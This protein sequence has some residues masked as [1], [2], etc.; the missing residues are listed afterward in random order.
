MGLFEELKRRNVFRVAIAYGVVAWLALQIA[1][2]MID[3]I[4][5]PDWLFGTLLL[6]LAI[7]FPVALVFAWAFEMTP[8]G[9][10]RESEVDRSRSITT[11]TG[12]RLD[13]VIIGVLV[14]ALGY[15]VLERFR[16]ME[17]PGDDPAGTATAR[18]GLEADGAGAPSPPEPPSGETAADNAAPDH[19]IAVLPFVNLSSDQEQEYFSD[20]IS[21]ELLN[22]LA[23]YPDLRV[24]ART[25]SFQFKGQN[26]DIG[27]IARLL[28][29]KHI[30]EG[31]VRKSGN[32]LR[33]TAQLIEADNGYHLWSQTY[34]RELKDVFA[35][36]DEI[37]AA[38]GEALRVQL[39]LDGAGGTVAPR[40][41][42][43]DNSV[44]YEAFLKGRGL[45]ALRGRR[46]ITEGVSELERSVRLDPEYA[47]AHAW[48]AIGIMLLLN[49]PNSYGDYTL[50]QV[51]E[52]AT[53]HIERALALEPDLAEAHGAQAL[54]ANQSGDFPKGIS[55]ANR[56]V[57]LNPVFVDALNWGSQS[58]QAMGD[59]GTALAMIESLIVVDPL[60]VVGRLNYV[61]WLCLKEPEQTRQIA[62]ELVE[63]S[64]WAG[65]LAKGF[66]EGCNRTNL[67]EATRW[68]LGAYAESPLDDFSNRQLIFLFSSMGE[69]DEA[70]RVSD[71]SSYLAD[72]YEGRM[73]TTVDTL[74]RRLEADPDNAEAKIRLADALYKSGQHEAATAIFLQLRE[75]FPGGIVSGGDY[76]SISHA[77]M[78]WSL[79]QTGEL[80]LAREASADLE[81]NLSKLAALDIDTPWDHVAEA[82]RAI[83]MGSEEQSLAALQSALDRHLW[84]PLY[85]DDPA[86]ASL[87]THPEF[88]AL[89]AQV[90]DILDREHAETLQLIC[91]D[92]PVP[93]SW[94]PL[95][96]TCAGITPR[97]G[98]AG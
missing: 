59:W 58:S 91:F 79:V 23:Q 52:L 13:F 84:D 78:V 80:E 35:I 61:A 62:D 60:S 55:S 10:K 8:E 5:A 73:E 69:Y 70:R 16:P 85:F 40:V 21:E 19:S 14:V 88:L 68:T 41:Q 98:D 11:Q 90:Q 95:D 2:V 63:T 47:P 92:N 18:T 39:D 83:A 7:G 3:N 20:G 25:S 6:V 53:P 43:T 71:Q 72:L 86:L 56:A 42:E 94:E 50:S 93:Q 54:M 89:R 51:Q 26:K 28:K 33:I 96:R 44:A 9:L 29:V 64:A 24:A 82:I 74:K 67:S 36:Q 30:L 45:I 37:S 76:F 34:D 49:S 27:E 75:G 46:N 12:R 32:Q 66:L 97:P 4:G 77:R 15:F 81:R 87:S 1:D 31:S 17:G 38:I 65:Y 22:V 48:L 57:A